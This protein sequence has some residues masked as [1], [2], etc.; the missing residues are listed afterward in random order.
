[1]YL[2]LVP[3]AVV[4]GARTAAMDEDVRKLDTSRV[5]QR[6]CLATHQSDPQACQ[7]EQAMFA[8][9]QQTIETRA[10]PDPA[11]QQSVA[12]Q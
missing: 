3:V 5:A 12:P 4:L 10:S 11:Y 2:A 6:T 7:A 8:A 9:D 1:M